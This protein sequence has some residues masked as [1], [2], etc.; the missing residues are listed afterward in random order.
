M[1]SASRTASD[2]TSVQQPLAARVAQLVVRL[3]KVPGL[4]N[5]QLAWAVYAVSHLT[6][7]MPKQA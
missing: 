1:V 4:D 2:S 5:G 6:R 7:K 3:A